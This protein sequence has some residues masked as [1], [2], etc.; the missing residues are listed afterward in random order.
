[1]RKV[2]A[3]FLALVLHSCKKAQPPDAKMLYQNYCLSCHGSTGTGNGPL[4]HAA[5]KKAANIRQYR[6]KPQ[7]SAKKLQQILYYG[8][9]G[10]EMPSFANV[11]TERE[12]RAL[13]IALMQANFLEAKVI[14]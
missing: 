11:M 1:M 4:M 5:G 6:K 2:V 8:I 14:H 9:A 3:V 10:T 13:S 7:A 12:L